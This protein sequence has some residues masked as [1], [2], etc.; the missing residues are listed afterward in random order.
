MKFKESYLLPF[1]TKKVIITIELVVL[2]ITSIITGYILVSNA[3]NNNNLNENKNNIYVQIICNK[4]TG[5]T[6]L[7][8][9]FNFITNLENNEKLNYQW[10]FGD[11]IISTEKIPI[12][13]FLEPGKYQTELTITDFHG[14]QVSDSIIINVEE[15]DPPEAKIDVSTITG[16]KPL[17]VYFYANKGNDYGI[18]SYLWRFGP[19]YKIIVSESKYRHSRFF[20]YFIYHLRNRE[21]ISNE[22]NPAMVFLQEG[23]YWAEL[24]ITTEKGIIDTD[25]IW[26][27]VYRSSTND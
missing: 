9:E 12:H 19:K 18:D 13:T 14:N 21:Y 27:H 3:L 16:L 17:L 11:G 22:R 5:K 4:T 24:T 20:R 8:I 6:P 7:E 26:I 25:K 1:V 23:N 10:D 15:P 2:L